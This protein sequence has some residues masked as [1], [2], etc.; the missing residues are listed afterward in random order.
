MKTTLGPKAV[1][2]IYRRIDDEY[3]D[4]LTFRPDSLLGIPGIFH[5]YRSGG[6]TLASAPGAGIADDKAVYIYVPEM[7]RF[8]LGEQPIL[9]NIQTWQCSR[10]DECAYVL[11]HL[12]E[13]VAKEVHGSGGYGLLIGPKAAKA[14]VEA[15]AERIKAN[16][17]EFI[18][19]PTMDLS[20]VPP[21]G[22]ARG[23]V[24]QADSLP[25][26]LFRLKLL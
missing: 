17:G 2:V 25:Y 11:E 10:P 16:P 1:D 19:Q 14:E 23:V 12:H 9:D 8:Y 24:R 15:Y 4:P 7:I 6:V 22:P 21:P 18:A 26:F 13:L 20:T 3:L 5:V